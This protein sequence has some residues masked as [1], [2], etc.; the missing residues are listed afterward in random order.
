MLPRVVLEQ[1]QSELCDWNGTG[2]SVMEMP[3]TSDRFKGIVERSRRDL[4]ALLGLPDNYKVLF[5]QG[6]AYA[7]FSLLAMNLMGKVHC[8]DYVQTG[9]WSSRAINEARRYGH[10]NIAASSKE[11]VFNHIPTQADWRLNPAAAYCHITTNETANGNQ[12][13]WTP[14]TGKV[15]LVADVTSDFLACEIE[16]SRYGMVYAS[17]QKNIGL[18]GLTLVIIRDDL[19]NQAM[20]I[21]PTVFNYGLQASNDSRINT[22]PTYNIYLAGLLFAWILAQGGVASMEN[23]N[24]RKSKKLYQFIDEDAFYHCPV[25]EADRSLLNV[26][27]FLSNTALEP[28]FLAEAKQAGLIHLDGHGSAGGIRASLYN[29]MPLAG[30]EVLID[31]MQG[32]ADKHQ[33]PP[34]RK[35]SNTCT[36][37]P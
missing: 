15:P 31:F 35:R 22:Q 16:L 32:F 25:R 18:A 23:A 24:R 1:A 5:M 10:I 2:M 7:H 34:P 8:A 20:Q 28:V 36:L 26:C 27:F 12:F 33:S 29:A 11:N 19:L 3:F 37:C 21:T 9:H 30:V 17:A 14:D 4:Q 13:H 6:G